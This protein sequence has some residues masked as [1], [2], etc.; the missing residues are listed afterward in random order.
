M[1]KLEDMNSK[2]LDSLLDKI[3]GI[4]EQNLPPGAVM[5]VVVCDKYGIRGTMGNMAQHQVAEILR[6]VAG[7]QDERQ[8][9]N[10]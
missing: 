8:A 4:L 2:E 9:R 3:T 7:H 6:Q 1:K 10:N 5:V